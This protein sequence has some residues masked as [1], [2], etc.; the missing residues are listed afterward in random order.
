MAPEPH[1]ALEF[2][3]IGPFT[4][5]DLTGSI[6]QYICVYIINNN[7]TPQVY[8]CL[9]TANHHNVTAPPKARGNF[10]TKRGHCW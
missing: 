6:D 2:L 3:C 9:L 7:F 5:S 10:K 1:T 8:A 4:K